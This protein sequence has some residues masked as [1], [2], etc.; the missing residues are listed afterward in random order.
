M[1]RNWIFLRGLGRHSAHWNPFLQEFRKHFPEDRVELLDLRGNGSLWHSPS[2]LSV[3]ENVRDLRG[4]SRW[5]QQGERVHLMT[6]SLGSMVGVEWAR[7]FPEEIAGLVTINTSDRGSS[8]FFER[9]RPANYL[10]FL[11]MLAKQ[12]N[13]A[14]VEDQILD[15][16]TKLLSQRASIRQEFAGWK[17]TT[18]INLL[19]QILAAGTYEF[20][21]QKPKTEILLLCSEGDRL[22][23]SKCTKNI[24][25]MW[26]LKAHVH[27]KAGHDLTLDAPDWVCEEIKNW[28]DLCPS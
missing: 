14:W 10:F 20:P 28:L 5:I 25:E 23:D 13:E 9:M 15:L 11:Q 1:S 16:T 17:T 19:K 18:R 24:A 22:V 12:R 8:P 26:T 6:I 27:S 21:Q 4:R 7:R 3:A 2:Y